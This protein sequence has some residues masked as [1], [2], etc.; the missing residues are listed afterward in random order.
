MCDYPG[1]VDWHE[2]YNKEGEMNKPAKICK[3]D[4]CKILEKLHKY[5]EFV[6]SLEKIIIMCDN[7]NAPDNV[8][9]LSLVTAL[10]TFQAE[11]SK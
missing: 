9:L 6:E 7:V 11:L 5:E 1:D 10:G 3:G 8:Y 4:D 2:S